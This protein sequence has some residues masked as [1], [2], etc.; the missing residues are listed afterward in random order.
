[1]ASS[2]LTSLPTELLEEIIPHTLPEGFE[3][4]ALT[5]R[6]FYNLCTPLIKRHNQLRTEFGEFMYYACLNRDG[7]HYRHHPQAIYLIQEIADDPV[8]ARYIRHADFI[9][10][11]WPPY[12]ERVQHLPDPNLGGPVVA[13]FSESPYLREAGLDWR[14]YYAA[15]QEDTREDQDPPNMYS[16]HAAAFLLTLL[17]NVTSLKLPSHWHPCE[18]ADRLILATVRKAASR[19]GHPSSPLWDRPSLAQLT[20]FEHHNESR[21]R[22]R[23]PFTRGPDWS[24]PDHRYHLA[25]VV[26]FLAL[27][28]LRLFRARSCVARE[29]AS[30]AAASEKAGLP[31]G[32]SLEYARIVDACLDEVAFTTFLRRAPNLKELVYWHCTDVH[33][34]QDW[35]ACGLVEAIGSEAGGRL[36]R[37]EVEIY[38]SRVALAPGRLSMRG[39][40]RLRRLRLPLEIAACNLAGGASALDKELTDQ[41]VGELQRL[42]DVLVPASLSS[43]TLDSRDPDRHVKVLGVMFRDLAARKD[44]WVPALEEVRLVPRPKKDGAYKD[45]CGRLEVEM[46]EAG[47]TLHFGEYPIDE[48]GIEWLD[49]EVLEE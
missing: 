43:L 33:A 27:P 9:Y 34:P 8:V 5:C 3:G 6:R 30:V 12:P 25:D 1:M 22:D 26:P 20:R 7:L 4:L 48:D 39:F 10:D 49:E 14:Q 46:M 40:Q 21:P 36:E 31:P 16:Q 28:E 42:T 47:V 11:T 32:G 38:G 23:V 15:I 44:D 17:P 18:M 19:P 24:P 37:L 45:E 13:L 35:D 29:G 2:T 41:E